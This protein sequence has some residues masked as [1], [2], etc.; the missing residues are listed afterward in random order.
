M[1]PE[2]GTL[3]LVGAGEFQPSMREI[4][5]ELLT[6]AGGRR[7]AILPTASAPDGPGVPERWAAMGVE[8]FA[9]L[10]A[11][12]EAVMA[13]DRAGCQAPAHVEAVRRA[14]LVYF[15][16]GKPDYLLKALRETPLWQAVEA[17]LERGGVLAGC[18]AGAMILGGW[19]PGRSSTLRLTWQPAFGLVPGVVIIPHYDE[20]PRWMTGLLRATAAR[21]DR[22]R[23][24]RR[25]GAHRPRRRL[26]VPGPRCLSAGPALPA[27][28]YR[29]LITG[30]LTVAFLH[31]V[32]DVLHYFAGLRRLS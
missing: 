29:L 8:H 28:D 17:V 16:G 24:P 11:Q 14:D 15:S 23:H 9:G 32:R 7:V 5:A 6:Q 13:L 30:P 21:L 12:A 4:D 2:R 10:G 18:S 1:T 22:G 19:I 25:H 27:T 31:P 26:D 3:A 20:I